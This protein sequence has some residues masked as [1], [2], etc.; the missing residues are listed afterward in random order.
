MVPFAHSAIK[1]IIQLWPLLLN[2]HRS[3]RGIII[4]IV[5]MVTEARARIAVQLDIVVHLAFVGRLL[6]LLGMLLM[7]LLIEV[8]GGDQIENVLAVVVNLDQDLGVFIEGV[9]AAVH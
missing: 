7:L 6:K 5:S 4:E 1:R 3:C 8:F 9:S 2:R